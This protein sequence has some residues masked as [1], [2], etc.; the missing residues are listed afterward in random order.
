MG[1]SS[2]YLMVNSATMATQTVYSLKPGNLKTAIPVF[3]AVFAMGVW[4]STF[5]SRCFEVTL[6]FMIP[7]Q[8]ILTFAATGYFYDGLNLREQIRT[9]LFILTVTFA[10]LLCNNILYSSFLLLPGGVISFNPVSVLAANAAAVI[11]TLP[12]YGLERQLVEVDEIKTPQRIWAKIPPLFV[13]SFIVFVALVSIILNP[14]Y[15]H[16]RALEVTVYYFTLVQFA[17]PFIATRFFFGSFPFGKRVRIYFAMVALALA[18]GA[19]ENYMYQHFALCVGF[20]IKAPASDFITMNLASVMA[21]VAYYKWK[22]FE[23]KS[24]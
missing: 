14:D 10:V 13:A 15:L 21:V 16:Y 2:E 8:F 5:C 22:Q 12:I 17:L 19:I 11:S 23:R 6:V 24:T 3:L 1:I 4:I 9:G 20:R 7:F 18:I